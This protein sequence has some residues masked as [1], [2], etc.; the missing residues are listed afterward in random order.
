MSEEQVMEESA[1]DVTPELEE[2]RKEASRFGWRPLEEWNGDEAA[3]VDA[4][5]FLARGKEYNGF[6][7]KENERLNSRLSEV[8][9]TMQEFAKHHET[10]AQQAYDRAVKDL[11]EARK[12]AIRNQ[13]VDAQL[14]VEEQLEELKEQRPQPARNPVPPQGQAE[15]QEWAGRNEWFGKHPAATEF[16]EDV[17]KGLA[18]KVTGVAF[19]QRI[20][21]AVR[22]EFPDLFSNP[23]RRSA[24]GVDGGG[25]RG[26][27][28]GGRSYSDLPPEA[29]A[30]CDKFV[31]QK[32][33][34]KEQ[35]VKEFF[36]GEE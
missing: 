26:T 30:A 31:R 22:A 33:M 12:E 8:E 2:A 28:R 34:T 15:F 7:K 14:Q 25:T 6:L 11:K 3:W 1:A 13:D 4:D 20:E 32:L 36:E 24:P 5:K 18:G 16:A 10:V 23:A 21:R 19:L 17:G 35:Y 9:K 27:G 29:R